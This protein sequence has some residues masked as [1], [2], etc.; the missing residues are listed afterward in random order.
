MNEMSMKTKVAFGCYL[1]LL[2]MMIS[3]G[4]RFATASE[5]RPHYLQAMAVQWEDVQPGVQLMFLT[6]LRTAGGI[7]LVAV[8]SIGV[9][10]F[11]PFRRGERW[12]RWATPALCIAAVIPIIA[13][14]F[15]VAAKTGASVPRVPLV[16]WGF[17]ALQEW[18]LQEWVPP[19]RPF[20]G[21]T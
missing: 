6:A 2:L 7:G 17:L 18:V 1:V 13:T 5:P 20:T 15:W 21:R 9:I 8:L 3:T 11:I 4:L 16:I 14:G 10:L 12:A 19:T